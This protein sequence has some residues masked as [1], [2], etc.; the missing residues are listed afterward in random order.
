MKKYST[1]IIVLLWVAS[2]TLIARTPQEAA[3]IASSFM[4]QRNT[5][6]GIAQRI[7]Q[8]QRTSAKSTV[9][10]AYTQHTTNN[11]DAV[12][13]FNSTTDGG[14][15]LISANDNSRTVLGYTDKG[16]FDANNIPRGM[17][18]WL[19]MYADEM[20]KISHKTIG[21][22][23]NGT[24]RR[25]GEKAK[26]QESEEL[27]PIIEPLLGEVAW[28]QHEPFNLL[29]PMIGE[30]HTL[31][32]CVATALSQIMYKHQYPT[33]GIGSFSYTTES[34]MTLSADFAATTYDWAN[35]LPTYPENGYTEEQA[36]AVATLTYHIG[37]ASSMEYGVDGSGAYTHNAL[38]NIVTYFGYDANI[39]SNPKDYMQE[40]ILL[41][42]IATDLQAGLPVYISGSTK[43][44]EGHAF[45]CDG[46]QEDG[47]IHINWGWYGLSN[48]YFAISALE[49]DRQGAGGSTGNL[50]FTEDVTVYTNIRPNQG[51]TTS[52]LIVVDKIRNTT[53]MTTTTNHAISIELESFK[54]HG[55]S[56]AAGTLGYYI[57]NTSNELVASIDTKNT[58]GLDPFYYYT[59]A[60][61]ISGQLSTELTDGQ[62]EL[63]IMYRDS[64]NDALK[65]ILVKELGAIRIP[66]TISGET[67]SFGD[68]PEVEGELPDEVR[69]L[70]NIDISNIIGTTSWQVDLYSSFFWS[71]YESTDE[72]LLRFIINSGDSTSAIGSYILDPNNSG[73]VGTINPKSNLY[74][75]GYYDGYYSFS[76]TDIH[77]TITQNEENS[78]QVQYYI[79]IGDSIED[80]S[81]FTATPEWFEYDR[82]KDIYYYHNSVTYDLVSS[83]SVN[84]ALNA[85]QALRHTNNTDISYYIGGIITTMRNTPEEIAYYK[86]ARFD[87]SDEST[88]TQSIYCYNSKW[89]K[90]SDFTTGTEISKGDSIIMCGQLKNYQG[91]TPEIIGHVYYHPN[92]K[93]DVGVGNISTPS[94]KASQKILQ[95]GQ[96]FIIYQ[97][98]RY[99]IVG[100]RVK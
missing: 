35:M 67:M 24:I 95:D 80:S 22:K 97:E 90:N 8:A 20:D 37:V 75:V 58:F 52:S 40:Q 70:T 28:G 64:T 56:R 12:Y 51:G 4:S 72:V 85:T 32:G 79:N 66:M 91:T 53:P 19:Q 92:H 30:E 93:N 77:L 68:I 98:N 99:N 62:Y 81:T 71:D 83:I 88:A 5:E 47:Y 69:P 63:E 42:S 76:L 43:N 16:S 33:N 17:Q 1:L 29:C 55:L 36:N 50:A 27:Y 86:T 44:Q 15:V 14:F 57:Y 46:M 7:Q 9:K 60:Y 94:N 65:P 74:A 18:F 100:A 96:L 21:Q 82:E 89:L 54:N 73:V 87:L 34:G 10:L 31:A 23:S 41:R 38:T 59:T 39:V 3:N 49:P 48:G 2:S 6:A 45:V 78:L 84:Q 26:R 61:K 25:I 13:V 11:E